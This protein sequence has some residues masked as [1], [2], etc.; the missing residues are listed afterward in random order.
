M[1]AATTFDAL[2]TPVAAER[3]D[4]QPVKGR[5]APVEAYMITVGKFPVPVTLVSPG[6]AQ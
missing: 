1:L 6:G 2:P 3:L 4:S 5:E